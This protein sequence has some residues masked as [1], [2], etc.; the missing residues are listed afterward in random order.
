MSSSDNANKK[1]NLIWL[2]LEMTGL[3]IQNDVIIEIASIITDQQLNILA[4]GPVLAIFQPDIILDNMNDWC[5]KQHSKSGLVDRVKAS[6]VSVAQAENETLKFWKEWVQEGESPLCGNSV[7]NDRLFL[8]KYM[9]KLEKFLHYR[10]LDV[11][12]PKLLSK[13]WYDNEFKK[14]SKHLALDDIKDSIEE[15]K[16]YRQNMFL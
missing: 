6:N 11:S 13:Y 3:D 12:T 4:E 7:H 16:F 9:Q 15:L 14:D 1:H 2:D 10:H 5:K 8:S